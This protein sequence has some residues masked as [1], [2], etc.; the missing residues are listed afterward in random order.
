MKGKYTVLDLAA[1]QQGI[2]KE[3]WHGWG[4][5]REHRDEFEERKLVI[6]DTV[7]KQLA[8]FCI[9]ITDPGI[10]PR[11]FER[12][13]ASIMSNLYKQPSPICDIPDKGMQLAPR[14]D[15]EDPIIVKDN[16]AAV[17]HGIP[18]FLEI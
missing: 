17:L 4:Y 10:E 1:V 11:I 14:W 18:A 8:G 5:A 9:F 13:E 2:R 3:V 12:L 15:S 7:R 16:C 6:L